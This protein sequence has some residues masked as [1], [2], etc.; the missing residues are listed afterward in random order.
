MMS[1]AVLRCTLPHAHDDHCQRPYTGRRRF[2]LRELGR[3][4]RPHQTNWAHA[5]PCYKQL[6][7]QVFF[8][9][10]ALLPPQIRHAPHSQ[11]MNRTIPDSASRSRIDRA[12]LEPPVCS[13]IGRTGIGGTYGTDSGTASENSGGCSAARTC[14]GGNIEIASERGKAECGLQDV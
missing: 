12:A 10:P 1:L 5:R 14:V 13:E 11:G 9:R 6:R 3:L 7:F 2:Y 4:P 8:F